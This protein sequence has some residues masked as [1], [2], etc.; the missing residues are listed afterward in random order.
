MT[1]DLSHLWLYVN[2]GNSNFF[3]FSCSF[4]E[5]YNKVLEHINTELL[6]LMMMIYL[7]H[8]VETRRQYTFWTLQLFD[9]SQNFIK[10]FASLLLPRLFSSFSLA[11]HVVLIIRVVTKEHF[12]PSLSFSQ[13]YPK[14]HFFVSTFTSFCFF[15]ISF[16]FR[17]LLLL[18]CTLVIYA[19]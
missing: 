5:I 8:S 11:F 9:F 4:I 14:L 19:K 1:F 16:L 18:D 3:V 2:F 13:T 10:S 15:L 12:I 7:K 17:I 6:I